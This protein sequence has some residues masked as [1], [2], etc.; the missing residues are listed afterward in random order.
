MP[1]SGAVGGEAF[2][3]GGRYDEVADPETTGLYDRRNDDI[4]VG[5]VERMGFEVVGFE[6]AL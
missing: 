4:S 6:V 3:A 2:L 1:Y 5:Q